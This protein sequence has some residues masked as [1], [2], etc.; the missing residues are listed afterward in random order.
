MK[1][2]GFYE[3]RLIK[4]RKATPVTIWRHKSL[5]INSGLVVA[6]AAAGGG[7]YLLIQPSASSAP[8]QTTAVQQGTVLATVSS[9]G[10]LEAAQNLGLNFT[11]G[12]KLTNIYVKV[13]QH[14]K[15]GQLLAS[16]DPTSSQQALTQAE[17]QLTTAEAQLSAAEA[18]ETPTQKKL[19]EDSVS[20]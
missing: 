5:L 14:G 12:G 17:T 18:A 11:T 10:T 20:S 6:L 4:V 1:S 16:V 19:Q 7:S 9:S 8:L 13:G 3:F 15:A 2:Q